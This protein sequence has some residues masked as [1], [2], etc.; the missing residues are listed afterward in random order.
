VA[1]IIW[2]AHG[3]GGKPMIIIMPG[4]KLFA[5]GTKDLPVT[6]QAECFTQACATQSVGSGG[7]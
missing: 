6:F 7:Y 3:D 1:G 4:A 5:A 2:R